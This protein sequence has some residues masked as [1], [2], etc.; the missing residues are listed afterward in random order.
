M[1]VI[2]NTEIGDV[3]PARNMTYHTADLPMMFRKTATYLA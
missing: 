3:N 1:S 2:P